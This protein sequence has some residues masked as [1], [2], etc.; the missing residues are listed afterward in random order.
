M[1]FGG[2]IVSLS[3]MLATVAG[4]GGLGSQPPPP[5]AP[6]KPA[7]PPPTVPDEPE[8]SNT[9]TYSGDT[10]EL[11]V[12]STVE[13]GR[14]R[15]PH[16]VFAGVDESEKRLI[17]PVRKEVKGDSAADLNELYEDVKSDFTESGFIPTSEEKG[18]ANGVPFRKIQGFK[19]PMVMH[20]WV[21]VKSQNGY[22]LAC[23]GL[24][25]QAARHV[26]VCSNVM[27]T[28]KLK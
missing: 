3:L 26:E 14:P 20:N 11:T 18:T 6:A 9:Q 17:L 23:G 5:E 19:P 16:V 10:W 1:K 13:R 8:P 4:C 25:T 24:M 28:L 7:L 22:L 2:L 27:R 15:N 21:L 12:P